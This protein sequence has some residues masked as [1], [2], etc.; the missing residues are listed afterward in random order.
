[1]KQFNKEEEKTELQQEPSEIKGVI[2]NIQRYSLHDGPGIRT[3]VFL[4]GCS[5]RCPWCA[6]PESQSREIELMGGEVVGREV[7]VGEVMEIVERDKPFYDRSGGGLTLSGGEPLQQPDFSEALVLEAKKR[8]IKVAIETS[9][10]QTWD[11]FWKV[12]KNIDVVLFDVKIMDS[13]K[14]KEII[15]GD[16]SIILSN[17]K[18]SA[19]LGKKIIVR[20]PI[21]PKYTDD[22]YNLNE[23]AKLSKDIGISEIHFLPYHQFGVHKYKK[24][25]REYRLSEIDSIPKDKIEAMALKIGQQYG[26][27]ITVY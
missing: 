22:L 7:T 1:M 25:D 12:V 18:K 6:N 8:G 23:I 9:G 24:L 2:Y 4:K 17:L 20:V 15:G 5:L 11:L 13:K 10:F 21:I 3:I 16:N 27:Q 19:E 26:I 14:H